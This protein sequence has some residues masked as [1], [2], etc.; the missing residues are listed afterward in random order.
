MNLSYIE[1]LE[2]TARD[3]DMQAPQ[4]LSERY[5]SVQSRCLDP[6]YKSTELR[7]VYMLLNAGTPGLTRKCGLHAF[8]RALFYVGK[9]TP[10]RPFKH[11]EEAR[12]YLLKPGTIGVGNSKARTTENQTVS[13]HLDVSMCPPYCRHLEGRSR[14]HRPSCN[15]QRPR[16]RCR[17]L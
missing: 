8:G 2:A 6:A 16:R 10:N 7:I 13:E 14:R 9:G 15:Y 12:N 4:A 3:V 1:Q 5:P 17:T 11:L